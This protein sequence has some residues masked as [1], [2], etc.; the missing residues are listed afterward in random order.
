MMKTNPPIPLGGDDLY[1]FS[2]KIYSLLRQKGKRNNSLPQRIQ[3]QNAARKCLRQ[4]PCKPENLQELQTLHRLWQLVDEPQQAGQ[5]VS[6][7]RDAILQAL[8]HTGTEK[9]QTQLHLDFMQIQSDLYCD[10]TRGLQKLH[11]CAQIIKT[12]PAQLSG[13][14]TQTYNQYSEHYFFY[15]EKNWQNYWV[16]WLDWAQK[17]RAW[18]LAQYGIEQRQIQN[19]QLNES[20]GDSS[21]SR[22]LA[23]MEKAYMARWH[24]IAPEYPLTDN[25]Y[26]LIEQRV[27]HYVDTAIAELGKAKPDGKADYF[28]HWLTLA[29]RLMDEPVGGDPLLPQ[30][31]PALMQA[32]RNYLQQHADN[33]PVFPV[34]QRHNEVRENQ[35]IATSYWFL[36]EFEKALQIAKKCYFNSEDEDIKDRF[37]S[38][39][40]S[41][42]ENNQQWDKL[43]CV[44]LEAV[45]HIRCD[46]ATT[47]YVIANRVARL[48]PFRYKQSAPTQATWHLIQAWAAINP[49][50][51]NLIKENHLAPPNTSRQESMAAVLKC[52]PNNPLVDLM[53]GWYLA[54]KMRWDEA[55][56]LL[57]RGISQSPYHLLSDDFIIKLWCARFAILTPENALKRPWYLAGGA[58]VNIYCGQQLLNFAYLLERQGIGTYWNRRYHAF[59][60]PENARIVLARY[61]LEAALK[62]ADAFIKAPVVSSVETDRFSFFDSLT[63]KTYCQLCYQLAGIYRQQQQG[64]KALILEEKA[65]VIDPFL[66]K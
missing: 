35:V 34:I 49:E 12:L 21:G 61:Y 15:C 4:T 48:S 6:Q 44:A 52:T 9:I 5:L 54:N 30:R 56:P 43:A 13:V 8:P 11:D 28:S 24:C 19:E 38:T 62:R 33:I 22:A 3:R 29:W 46:S 10:K 53:Q 17:Y 50:I 59:L 39:Y 58:Y 47:A 41:L 23:C 60:V 63:P 32:A 16:E 66:S 36:D 14:Y 42:L 18:E 20:K 65:S 45:L 25:E 37:G 55:L 7:Y 64:D 40:L 26:N 51:K 2:Q 27:Y 1:Q 31:V 57:E